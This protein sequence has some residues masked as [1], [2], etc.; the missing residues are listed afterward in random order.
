MSSRKVMLWDGPTRLF[1]WSVVLLMG[2]S[3]VSIDN[4]QVERHA[5]VGQTLLVLA[6]YRV[7]WGFVGGDTAR[8]RHF[9][10]GPGA[11]LA[12]LRAVRSGNKP[13]VLG[14]NP[15]GGWM[16]VALLLGLLIQGGSGLFTNENTFLY[17]DAP[18]ASWVGTALSD[19]LTTFHKSFF[20][21]LAA[22]VGVH[23]GAALTYLVV[24]KENLIRPMVTGSRD[25]ETASLPDPSLRPG[26]WLKALGCLV[27]SA[28]IVEGG[29][30]ILG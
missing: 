5:L 29:V 23:V 15:A 14:H 1:H 11:V 16:I 3:W 19:A 4:T 8:F 30:W 26:S 17:Y 12:Y 9:L 27:L 6:L 25:V 21:V 22:G 7:L 28:G 10:R 13:L 18:L 24:F 20:W 2:M